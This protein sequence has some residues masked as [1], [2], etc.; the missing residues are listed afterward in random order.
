MQSMLGHAAIM[1]DKHAFR[2]LK[3]LQ[4]AVRLES[5]KPGDSLQAA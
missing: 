1:Q 4:T 3:T 2:N 5:V